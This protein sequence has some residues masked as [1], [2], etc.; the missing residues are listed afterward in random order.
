MLPETLL[1]DQQKLSHADKLRV[2]QMVANEL[3][4]EEIFPR[5]KM[6][7]GRHLM[8]LVRRQS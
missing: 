1:T 2:V 7:S 6:Q 8:R 4:L 3:L 5:K